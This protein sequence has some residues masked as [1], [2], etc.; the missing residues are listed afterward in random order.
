V[1]AAEAR[2]GRSRSS[3]PAALRFAPVLNLVDLVLNIASSMAVVAA[4][5]LAVA[6]R[7]PSARSKRAWPESEAA[8]DAAEALL[9]PNTAPGIRRE[10]GPHSTEVRV[11]AGPRTGAPRAL[12]R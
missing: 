5:G 12:H 9:N 11:G 1:L 3:F 2:Y 8:E 10:S 4:I 6:W 7:E